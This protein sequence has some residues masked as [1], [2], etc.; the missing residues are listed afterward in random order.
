MTSPV[1]RRARTAGLVCGAALAL[2]TACSGSGDAGGSGTPAIQ[3]GEGESAQSGSAASASVGGASPTGAPLVTTEVGL[4]VVKAKV[5]LLGVTR[6]AGGLVTARVRLTSI[7]GSSSD[8]YDTY[9]WAFDWTKEDSIDTAY[10]LDPAGR[11]KY[12]AVKDSKGDC[13][14]SHRENLR[15]GGQVTE[16]YATFPPVPGN[17]GS[18]TIVFP[19]VPP[20]Q[21]V[22]PGS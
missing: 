5:E 21:N 10:L 18:L 6:D 12:L 20:F 16:L 8:V 13:L 7:G 2:A 15:G 9:D 1:L 14:C 22:T 19:D 4:G 11:K 17:P 3:L